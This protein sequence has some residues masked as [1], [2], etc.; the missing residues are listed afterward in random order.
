MY[1]TCQKGLKPDQRMPPGVL[2]WKGSAVGEAVNILEGKIVV[3]EKNP[4]WAKS[5]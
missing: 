5:G 2:P 3:E 4:S 1:L